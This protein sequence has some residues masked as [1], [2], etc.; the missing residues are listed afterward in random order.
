MEPITERT[1]R[2]VIPA[3]PEFVRV[4]R[5]VLED[6]ARLHGLPA[7]T[8]ADLKLAVTEACANA[9][10]HAYGEGGGT[11]EVV[12]ELLPDRIAFE[13]IDTGAGFE[14]GAPGED[15]LGLS[16]LRGLADELEISA[17]DAGG[18]SRLRF[19]KVL[20]A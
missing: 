5:H 11:I 1:V 2:L 4:P 20:P 18:G 6:L 8:L 10:T 12:F 3:R 17:R 15:G 13:V 14:P 19:V 16:I 9:V 7:E